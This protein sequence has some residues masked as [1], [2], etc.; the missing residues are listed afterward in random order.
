MIHKKLNFLLQ[1]K[2]QG[3]TNIVAKAY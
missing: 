2:L 1:L 3:L